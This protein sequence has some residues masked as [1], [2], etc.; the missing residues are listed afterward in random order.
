MSIV[1]LSQGVPFFHAGMDMLRSKSLDRN[2]YD[3]GDWFNKL[4]FTY[5][6]NNWGVGLPPAQ[7]N[8]E[9]WPLM[10]PLLA[11]PNLDPDHDDIM[12]SVHHFREIL[13]IREDTAL[14]RLE[15]AQQISES[16]RF[17][18]TGPDQLPGLIVMSISD[19]GDVDYDANHEMVVTLFNAND[20]PQTFTEAG[21][22][23]RMLALHPIQA[24][25]ADP[26]VKTSTYD[27]ATGTFTVPARTTAVF[28]DVKDPTAL[29][30]LDFGA[31]S[32]AGGLG[33]PLT[34]VGLT[35]VAGLLLAW[36]R[37]R[38]T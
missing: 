29:T 10:S 9:N 24:N 16:L 8:Q 27:N 26:V 21:L 23:G 17:H 6:D 25:S 18:N 4:D 35:L 11:D 12:Q 36:R 13:A 28:V 37:R 14:F 19:D 3:S 33:F 15:T 20:E 32:G 1:G 22:A 5:Q 31:G 38:T 2:S 30:T 7:D 34:L